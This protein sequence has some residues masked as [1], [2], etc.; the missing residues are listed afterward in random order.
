MTQV[1][2]NLTQKEIPE[3]VQ[4]KIS[5]LLRKVKSDFQNVFIYFSGIIPK[6]LSDVFES[7]GMYF[8]SHN[9]FAFNRKL[10][11]RICFGRIKYL[12]ERNFWVDLFSRVIFLTF[13]VNLIS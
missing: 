2:I 4:E 8:I 1:G 13:Y 5:K 3:I 9:S 6:L 12:K 7:N 10:K 11:M